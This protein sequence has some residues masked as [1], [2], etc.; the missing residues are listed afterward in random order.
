MTNN[1]NL[2]TTSSENSLIL[3]EHD[4]I[5]ILVNNYINSLDITQRSKDNYRKSLKQFFLYAQTHIND[6]PTRQDIIEYK[7]YL[8]EIYKPC[9]TSAYISA[10]K[11]FFSF[12]QAERIYPNITSGI[13]GT[14]IG[15]GYKKDNLTIDQAKKVL[16]YIKENSTLEGLRNRALITILITTGLRT[17][18]IERA[19]IED[20]R[21]KGVDWVLYIQGKGKE[22][23][24]E[25]VKIN[26]D[27]LIILNKYLETRLD[28]KPGDPLFTSLSDRN[29]GGRLTT[30]S[31]RRIIKEIFRSVGINSDRITAH[32]LRHTAV[33]MALVAGATT[34]QAQAMAR[35][36]NI[37]TT[38][39]YA[40]NIDRLKD[41]PEDRIMSLLK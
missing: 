32:S 10:V 36:K 4:S 12:L 20:F 2:I 21:Q 23:K 5:N 41:A 3:Q 13:K 34:Q 31:I 25:F 37:N 14:K 7:N 17:I 15:S 9:T 19:N 18:E 16:E 8:K 35:H 27:V 28:N 22:D 39:I 30:R 26:A 24:N 1:E 29:N 11:S 38:M 33:T 40:H 6:K